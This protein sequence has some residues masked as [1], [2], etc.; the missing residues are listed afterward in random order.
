MNHPINSN[1]EK[2]NKNFW[3]DKKLYQIVCMGLAVV[4]AG[5]VIIFIAPKVGTTTSS[6]I[7]A[8]AVLPLAY[9]AMFNKNGLDFVAFMKARRNNIQNGKLLCGNRMVENNNSSIKN[10]KIIKKG[11]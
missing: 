1:I 2:M 5:V 3:S 6:Y 11:R 9:V 10:T 8:I 7:C 4:I